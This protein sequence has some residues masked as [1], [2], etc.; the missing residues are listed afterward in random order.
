MFIFSCIMQQVSLKS[1]PRQV[2]QLIT[3]LQ[4]NLNTVQQPAL[5]NDTLI[6][7]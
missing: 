3:C 6:V 4:A 5:I 1:D 7:N 2:N